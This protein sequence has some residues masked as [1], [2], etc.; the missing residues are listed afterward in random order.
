MLEVDVPQDDNVTL[1]GHKKA[2]YA[3]AADGRIQLVES[4]GWEVEEIVT[5][6]AVEECDRQGPDG[7]ALIVA[8][9]RNMALASQTSFAAG[10]I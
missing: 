2:V 1:G 5:R 10:D 6:Q 3:R 7:R 8:S 4:S 9:Q